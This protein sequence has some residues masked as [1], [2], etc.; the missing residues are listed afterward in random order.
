MQLNSCD[1]GARSRYTFRS[2]GAF[3]RLLGRIRARSTNI[4]TRAMVDAAPLEEEKFSPSSAKSSHM[5]GLFGALVMRVHE[6][7][8]ANTKRKCSNMMVIVCHFI[9][10]GREY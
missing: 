4:V 5:K 8:Q 7:T 9:R 6:N 2:E 3:G 10:R 1:M